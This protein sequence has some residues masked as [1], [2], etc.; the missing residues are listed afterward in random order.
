MS[1]AQ[2]ILEARTIADMTQAELAESVGCHTMSVSRWERAEGEL[3][4][5]LARLKLIAEATGVNIE[6]L[7]G[8]TDDPGIDA[9]QDE[10][11]VADF[12]PKCVPIGLLD[13]MVGRR[14]RVSQAEFDV[15][16]QLI[17]P[18]RG[19]K[20]RELY[21][22]DSGDWFGIIERVAKLLRPAPTRLALLAADDSDAASHPT[23][24]LADEVIE[25][26][27]G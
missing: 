6:F 20:A 16:V 21:E 18:A 27:A 23:A 26:L 22:L 13:A 3:N 1:L 19:Q 24:E 9:T 11:S 5:P 8:R 2:R 7:L 15:L 12:M 25:Q 10:E 17:D 4:I 14:D